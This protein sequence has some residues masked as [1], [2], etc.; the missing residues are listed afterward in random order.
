MQDI[1]DPKV[2]AE[3]ET[4]E[5]TLSAAMDTLRKQKEFQLYVDQLE[6]FAERTKNRVMELKDHE[7]I[8]IL[9]A[10]Y[11]VLNNFIYM[12]RHEDPNKRYPTAT[13]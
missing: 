11:Q 9:Q 6:V 1:N 3:M 4:M 5:K 8:K 2:R 13:E 12:A 7:D 10:Y